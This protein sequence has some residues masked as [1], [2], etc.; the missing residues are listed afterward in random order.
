M[1]L[2]I[3]KLKHHLSRPCIMLSLANLCINQKIIIMSNSQNLWVVVS[4]V[5]LLSQET[6]QFIQLF[7]L[8]S[9]SLI[10]FSAADSLRN[11]PANA[12]SSDFNCKKFMY[13]QIK[14]V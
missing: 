13:Q 9:S 3:S 8:S 14:L 7:N 12:S 2:L 6:C 10:V 11:A 5:F 4:E 1:N